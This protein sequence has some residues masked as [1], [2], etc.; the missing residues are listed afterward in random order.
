MYKKASLLLA[1]FLFAVGAHLRPCY[2]YEL[3]GVCIA[4]GLAP[5][6]A[7]FAELTARAAA[8][9]ILPGHAQLPAVH[10]HLRLCFSTPSEDTHPLTDALLRATEGIVLREEVRVDG[11]RLGWVADGEALREALSTYIYNTLP[12]WASG[13]VLSR[14]LTLRRLYTRDAYLT[15]KNDM[16]LLITGAAPVFYYDQAGR[17][18]RA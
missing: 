1:A 8:E 10:K 5:F 4:S 16:V 7:S 13:G 18:A 6:A 3:D 11:A 2:D 17:Y 14:E 12:V 15:P 9:E